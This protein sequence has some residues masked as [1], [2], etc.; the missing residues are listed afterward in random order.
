MVAERSR[1]RGAPIWRLLLVIVPGN[2]AGTWP[3]TAA[4][5]PFHASLFREHPFVARRA[6]CQGNILPAVKVS[7]A[8]A[9]H[10]YRAGLDLGYF[11]VLPGFGFHQQIDL[12]YVVLLESFSPAVVGR[13]VLEL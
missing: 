4:R 2:G 10:Y 6:A 8:A 12:D 9:S 11:D 1:R 13:G 5:E 3:R 7:G